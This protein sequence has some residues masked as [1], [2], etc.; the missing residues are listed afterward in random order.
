MQ[1][2]LSERGTRGH[3]NYERALAE[4]A[5]EHASDGGLPRARRAVA[6]SAA[7]TVGAFR[8]LADVAVKPRA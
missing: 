3:L 4:L 6:P 8:A 2:K 1:R 5:R 7:P